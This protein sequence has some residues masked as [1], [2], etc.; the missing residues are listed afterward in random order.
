LARWKNSRDFKKYQGR[1]S[2]RYSVVGRQ[3]EKDVSEIL[4]KMIENG[5]I[6]EFEYFKPNSHEDLNGKDFSVTHNINGVEEI[7]YF[8][9][10]I[11]M[12]RWNK[13]RSR[14]HDVP[15]LCFPIGT[16]PETIKKRILELF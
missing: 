14:Y 10:T 8:G 9:V 4:K 11:S 16:K 2:Q 12:R 13:A 6:T 5:D 3:L 1:K 7:R 15:Q